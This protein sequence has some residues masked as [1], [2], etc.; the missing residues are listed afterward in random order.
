[1]TGRPIVRLS[2]STDEQRK[3]SKNR[4]KE[5]QAT[6]GCDLPVADLILEAIQR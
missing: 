5:N 3:G 1:M 4:K 2:P 6:V